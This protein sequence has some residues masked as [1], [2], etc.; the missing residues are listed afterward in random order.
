M[1]RRLDLCFADGPPAAYVNVGGNVT[2][3]GWINE[4]HLLDNGLVRRFP[5]T[6][7]PKRGLLFRM[8][9]RGVPVVHLLDIERLAAAHDLPIAPDRL[10]LLADFEGARR[11]QLERLLLLLSAWLATGVTGIAVRGF[12]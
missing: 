10:E 8:H 12:A 1:L 3:L 6:S 5:A 2:A 4:T 9:E 11:R 7:A